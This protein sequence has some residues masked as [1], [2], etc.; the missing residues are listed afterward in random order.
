MSD[1][2]LCIDTSGG[3]CAAAL[4]DG[5]GTRLLGMAAP[6]IGRGH[7]EVLMGLVADILAGA[8][9]TYAALGKIAVVVGPGSFTGL[10]VGVAAAKGLALALAIPLVGASTLEILAE[11]HWHGNGAVLAV[12]DAK[13][14]E[15]YAALYGLGGIVL[16]EPQAVRPESL[17][18]LVATSAGSG[19][20]VAVGTGAA[21]A[22]EILAG[23]L[24]CIANPEGL[25]DMDAFARLAAPRAPEGSLRLLYL[26]G[27]DA[28]PSAPTGILRATEPSA[29]S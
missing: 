11:P 13:R 25:V 29:V 28:K 27:A 5:G 18:A 7:A 2:L 17:A 3:R 26:R 4:Y 14:G 21:I 9:A 6:D 22:R 19:P 20:L 8:G 23:T 24:A 16:A 15:V 12:N 1:L 10:R